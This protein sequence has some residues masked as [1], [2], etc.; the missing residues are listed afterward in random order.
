MGFQVL[1]DVFVGSNR[2]CREV[3]RVS[4]KRRPHRFRSERLRKAR[5]ERPSDSRSGR[6]RRARR[7]SGPRGGWR[8]RDR[9]RRRFSEERT[10]G[11]NRSFNGSRQGRNFRITLTTE[12]SKSLLTE[13]IKGRKEKEKY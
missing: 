3:H 6:R 9:R 4:Q 11:R 8:V 10:Q 12:K 1:Q 5:R 13:R 7:R 2:G